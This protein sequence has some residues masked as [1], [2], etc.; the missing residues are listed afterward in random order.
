MIVDGL[1]VMSGG[2]LLTDFPAALAS[3]ILFNR[4]KFNVYLKISGLFSISSQCPV[5]YPGLKHRKKNFF[6]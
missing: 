5:K 3:Q 1:Q 2:A 6:L 4:K